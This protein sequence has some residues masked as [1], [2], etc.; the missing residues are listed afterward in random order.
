MLKFCVLFLRSNFVFA[1][2]VVV[3][4][5]AN[6]PIRMDE[7]GKKKAGPQEMAAFASFRTFEAEEEEGGGK[8]QTFRDGAKNGARE[9]SRSPSPRSKTQ[10]ADR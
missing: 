2:V 4:S 7:Q 10:V 3:E 5:R 1:D 8:A 6:L 9:E